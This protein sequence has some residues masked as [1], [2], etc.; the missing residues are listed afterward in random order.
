LIALGRGRVW[1][2]NSVSAKKKWVRG[3]KK[4]GWEAGLASGF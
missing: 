1:V 2:A 4:Y 3:G